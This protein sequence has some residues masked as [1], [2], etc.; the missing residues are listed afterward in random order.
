MDRPPQGCWR[1]IC[2]LRSFSK[3]LNSRPSRYVQ[4]SS[5]SIR[6][7][8]VF[9]R[10]PFPYLRFR[11]TNATVRRFGFSDAYLRNCDIPFPFGCDGNSHSETLYAINVCYDCVLNGMSSECGLRLP[12]MLVS[13]MEIVYMLVD[14]SRVHWRTWKDELKSADRKSVV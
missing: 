3:P 6:F 12:L 1:L 4:H 8:L 2:H 5:R 9:L 10:N 7:H 11:F 14:L 13:G